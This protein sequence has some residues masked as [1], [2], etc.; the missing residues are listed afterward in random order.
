MV[1]LA[2]TSA[3]VVA[4]KPVA[5]DQVKVAPVPV[6]EALKVV[7]APAQIDTFGLTVTILLTVTVVVAL[8]AQPK[9]L[10]PVTV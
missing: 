1:G 9:E 10:V 6:D 7:E 3:P 4:D 8:V 5:G 2:V